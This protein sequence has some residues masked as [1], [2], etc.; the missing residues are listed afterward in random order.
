M[1]MVSKS[2]VNL[3]MCSISGEYDAVIV[4]L[5]A[6]S[7]FLPELSGKLPLRTCRGIIAHLHLPDSIRYL[8]IG[9]KDIIHMCMH[10]CVLGWMWMQRAKDYWAG[11]SDPFSI[12]VI[13][14]SNHS[15]WFCL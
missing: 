13:K 6:R 12:T 5:G 14:F 11:K 4:C 15:I 3:I 9:F 10:A 2:F 7:T 8:S 1:S